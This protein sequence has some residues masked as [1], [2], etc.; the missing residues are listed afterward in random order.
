MDVMRFSFAAVLCLTLAT[1][2]PSPAFSQTRPSPLQGEFATAAA[3]GAKHPGD[4]V[5]FTYK[6]SFL[7]KTAV[8]VVKRQAEWLKAH[9]TMKV[10]LECF[11]DDDFEEMDALSFGDTRC[12]AVETVLIKNGISGGRISAL[13]FGNQRPAVKDAKTKEEHTQNRR[14]V[15]VLVSQ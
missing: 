8:D 10:R 4:T 5:T 13:S 1:A 6:Q 9:P 14:V 3:G 7:T 11:T 15:T 12:R 2:L